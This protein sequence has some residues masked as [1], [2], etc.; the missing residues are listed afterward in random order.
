MQAA[1]QAVHHFYDTGVQSL[2]SIGQSRYGKVATEAA[3]LGLSAEMLRKARKF[4]NSKDGGYTRKELDRLC[5]LCEENGFAIGVS[6]VIVL[7]SVP[8]NQRTQIQREAIKGHW[9]RADLELEKKR[10]FGKR[11]NTA[12]TPRSP[13]NLEEAYLRLAGLC[14]QWKR[15]HK[16]MDFYS[17][18]TDGRVAAVITELPPRFRSMLEQTTARIVAMEREATKI[19]SQR[20]GR[21]QAKN[22]K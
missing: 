6:H 7:L 10:R 11:R 19:M 17:K 22:A 18:L 2:A 9:S 3:E 20:R 16:S 4:A 8:K 13:R 14:G 21:K 1:V 12:K 5:R 15:F